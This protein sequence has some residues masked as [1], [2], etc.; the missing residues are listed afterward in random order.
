MKDSLNKLIEAARKAHAPIEGTAE[1]APPGFA[2]RIVANATV[3][4][5]RRRLGTLD[6]LE[7]L[8]W[9]G[10]AASAAICLIAVALHAQHPAPNPFD[11]LMESPVDPI[12][13]N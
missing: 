4:K 6:L 12:E 13:M 7:R 3:G 8:G 1:S 10:A 9:C 11:I 2:G 5:A